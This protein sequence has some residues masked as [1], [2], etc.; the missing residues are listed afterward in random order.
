[1]R[2][3]WL[4]SERRQTS[5]WQ[6]RDG[7]ANLLDDGYGGTGRCE[8][9]GVRVT[10]IQP[11]TR[12]RCGRRSRSDGARECCHHD[13]QPVEGGEPMARRRQHSRCDDRRVRRHR[14]GYLRASDLYGVISTLGATNTRDRCTHAS[15]P[16][17]ENL[18]VSSSAMA[19]VLTAVWSGLGVIARVML[20]R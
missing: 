17:A 16:A 12:V 13:T 7:G 2:D 1:M 20:T 19:L 8:F 15:V 6:Y 4:S 5:M 10:G 14:P 9:V 11:R 3:H 18:P